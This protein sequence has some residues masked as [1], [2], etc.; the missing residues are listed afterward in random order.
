MS[1]AM[2]QAALDRRLGPK[3]ALVRSLGFGPEGEPAIADAVREM[4]QRGLDVSE[5]R[6]LR[7]TGSRV[8]QADLIL[9]SEKDHVIGVAAESPEAARRSF[10]LPEFLGLVLAAGAGGGDGASV[11]ARPL[12]EW[13]SALSVDRSPADYLA[14]PIPE[15]DD[16]TGSSPRRFAAATEAI[17]EMCERV[18]DVLAASY[19]DADDDW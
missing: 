2:L 4:A 18:A 13:A 6:S 17:E 9:T 3:R 15:I 14:A 1:M 11:D 10:T 8:D 19:G 7:V 5:H 16:P 12:A